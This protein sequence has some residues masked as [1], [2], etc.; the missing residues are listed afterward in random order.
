TARIAIRRNIFGNR[1]P[2]LN[3][4]RCRATPRPVRRIFLTSE[5]RAHRARIPS[6]TPPRLPACTNP[7][8][9]STY[10]IVHQSRQ[11]PYTPRALKTLPHRRPSLLFEPYR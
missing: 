10:K 8:L 5:E 1:S 11:F 4:N 9:P 6:P 3:E 2:D 7:L